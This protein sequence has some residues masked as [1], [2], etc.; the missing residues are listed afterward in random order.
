MVHIKLGVYWISVFFWPWLHYIQHPAIFGKSGSS[1][2]LGS[3]GL[4]VD[5]LQPKVTKLVLVCH[6]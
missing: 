3:V 6:Q 1:Q 4:N 5:K 2:N